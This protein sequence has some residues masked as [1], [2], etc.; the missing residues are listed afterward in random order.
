M[1]KQ[2]NIRPK[3]PPKYLPVRFVLA[4]NCSVWGS[5]LSVVCTLSRTPLEK[6]LFTYEW[7]LLGDSFLDGGLASSCLGLLSALGPFLI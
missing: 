4:I 6:Q 7:L 1:P 3:I 2:S 5:P